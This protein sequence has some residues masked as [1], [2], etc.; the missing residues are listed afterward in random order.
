MAY[1]WVNC[2]AYSYSIQNLI[3][4]HILVIAITH[5]VPGCLSQE[6]TAMLPIRMDCG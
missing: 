4:V 1:L 3:E 2:I 5:E 6:V